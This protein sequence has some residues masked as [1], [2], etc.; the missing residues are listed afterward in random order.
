[1]EVQQDI[2]EYL[3]TNSAEKTTIEADDTDKVIASIDSLDTA[4]NVEAGENVVNDVLTVCISN[5]LAL[6]EYDR[7]TIIFNSIDKKRAYLSDK[8]IFSSKVSMDGTTEI[9]V[10]NAE[11]WT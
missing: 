2:F 11:L 1:M 5:P 4:E 6:G 10:L 7:N 8:D 3:I 9:V